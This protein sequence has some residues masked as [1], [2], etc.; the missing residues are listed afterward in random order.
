MAEKKSRTLSGVWP[1][2]VAVAV[3]S[4]F[5][6][7]HGYIVVPL[8]FVV[9]VFFVMLLG[10]TIQ[11]PLL[12]ITALFFLLPF[13]RIPSLQVGGVT[14]RLSQ[15]LLLCLIIASILRLLTSKAKLNFS[16]Y[17]YP[18]LFFVASLLLSFWHMQAVTRGLMVFAFILFTSLALWI[19]PAFIS[20]E[21]HIERVVRAL[22]V[23]T[24][25]ISIFGLYQFVGD[26]IGLPNTLTGL[27]ELYTKVV[28][29]FPR[30]QATALEPLY[31]ANFLIIP[32]SLAIAYAV[33]SLPQFRTRLYAAVIG[34]GTVV[35]ILTLARGGYLGFAASLMVLFVASLYKF[36]RPAMVMA[37]LGIII[38]LAV[39]IGGLFRFSNLGQK[40]IDI[41]TTHFTQIT[42]DASTLDRFGSFQDAVNAFEQYP[43]TGV[44]VGNYGPWTA[45]YPNQLPPDGWRI[46]NNEPL[47]ILAETGVIG[48]LS[49]L[50]LGVLLFWR[51][52]QAIFMTKNTFL[53]ATLVGLLAAGTGIVVQYQFFSTLY[54]MHIWV[55]FGFMIA[56]QNIV[57][58][59]H[60]A[61][62]KGA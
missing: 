34:L 15:I 4:G 26:M 53:R 10:W 8:L 36:L 22:F 1:I 32:L 46:V 43:W 23:V 29:G 17:L 5:A 40:S 6:F 30:V 58:R 48:L 45:H 39:G 57:S 14:V 44:G 49:S 56:V 50:L 18:Y 24:I 2:L 52:V 37:G 21:E 59:E 61:P 51:T 47:E 42:E 25:V 3:V 35:L 13:E 55:L 33:R 41:T 28:F 54:I 27:R 60:E 12:A 7:A 19:V 16:P 31:L 62:L 11:E 20:K 9:A 38:V